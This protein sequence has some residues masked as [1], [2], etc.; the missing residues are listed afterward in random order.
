MSDL[1][2]FRNAFKG[3]II[4]PSD[5]GYERAIVRW[6]FNAM[7]RAHIVAYVRDAADVST[8][9]RYAKANGVKIAVHG[10][11]HSPSGASSSEDGLVVDLSR[12]VNSVWVDPEAKLAYVGGGATWGMVDKATMEHGLA[13]TGGTVSHVRAFHVANAHHVLTVASDRSRRVSSYGSDSVSRSHGLQS[14]TVG[15]GYGWLSPMHGLTIDH[16]RQATVVTAD[17]TIH[18]ASSTENSD[19]FWGI[20]GGGSN[21]GVVT[22]FVFHLHP[23]RRTVFGG[24]VLFT[25]D[26]VEAIA[27]TIEEWF[28]S[29][30][31][32]E[33][34]HATMG[35][36]PDGTVG[37]SIDRCSDHYAH[38]VLAFN[39]A[40]DVLQRRRSRRTRELQELYSPR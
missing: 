34:L 15:G 9:L 35:R 7:R 37:R 22:E 8:A 27:R 26:K 12:Y 1:S 4:T 32:K 16:L 25:R 36:T 38:R 29:A 21:F 2:S 30:G 6:A 3:D 40:L 10:G 18:T 33:A 39:H 5:E 24:P 17:G 23:Q 13:M 19:L 11:G 14:L 20:R 28:L 31:P